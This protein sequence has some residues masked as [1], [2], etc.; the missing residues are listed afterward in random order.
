MTSIGNCT[1]VRYRVGER[2]FDV[3]DGERKKKKNRS[4]FEFYVCYFHKKRINLFVHE[5]ICLDCSRSRVVP[6]LGPQEN[7]I[8]ALLLLLSVPFT[9]RNIL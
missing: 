8:I 2:R 6:E 4:N 7:K 3:R 5:Y 9:G 1:F